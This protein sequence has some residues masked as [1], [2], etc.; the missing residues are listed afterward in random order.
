MK[1]DTK[2]YQIKQGGRIAFDTGLIMWHHFFKGECM[3]EVHYYSTNV[4][5]NEGKTG[6][7]SEPTLPKIEV[8]T[9]PEFPGGVPNI[10]SPE[11]LYVAA[12][13]AC[14]MTTF[15]AIAENS[16][17]EFLSYTCEGTG[18][19][20]RVEKRFMVSEI[21]L[22]PEIVVT[23]DHA[24]ERARRIIEK[25]EQACLITNSM[26]TKVFLSPDIRTRD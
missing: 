12:A 4:T 16:K 5:W 25:A 11:H 6:D 7:L 14:L 24:A 23:D 3:E 2:V 18:K 20:E 9:P 1:E 10:W 17:L 19:L 21:E 15:L 26:K 13:N 22:K 8:A